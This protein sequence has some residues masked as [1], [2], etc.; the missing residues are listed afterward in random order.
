LSANL[1]FSNEGYIHSRTAK[2]PKLL[3]V[4]RDYV[5]LIGILVTDAMKLS[6]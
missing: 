1:I 6:F 3:V 5:T 2:F 4:T